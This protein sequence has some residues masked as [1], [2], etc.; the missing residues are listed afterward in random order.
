MPNIKIE[1]FHLIC[2]VVDI[3]HICKFLAFKS[4]YFIQKK[5]TIDVLLLVWGRGY[6]TSFTAMAEGSMHTQDIDDF[7]AFLFLFNIS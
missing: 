1:F 7:E 6:A 2:L 5:A 4:N 3:W